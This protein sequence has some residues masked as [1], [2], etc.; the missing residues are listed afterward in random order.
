MLT[1]AIAAE[2]NVPF[3]SLS[4]ADLENKYFGESSK[5]LAAT[6]SYARKIQP[7]VIFFDEIDGL[8]RQRS[9]ADQSCVYGFKT[10][11]LSQMD[12]ML[13]LSSDRF[14]VIGCTNC[15]AQLDSAVK[16]RLP[17]QLYVGHPTHE[18]LVDIFKKHT[19][20]DVKSEDLSRCVRTMR[21]HVSGSDVAHIVKTAWH[22]RMQD[23]MAEAR[24]K[25]FLADPKSTG[26]EMQV[27]AGKIDE[28]LL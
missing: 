8:I 14:I 18:E 6:F 26:A 1:R 12:G 9:D 21:D 11:F 24:F 2:A 22:I 5:L 3:I 17:C 23:L 13:R 19:Y 20:D 27:L 10:E 16:R 15:L 25:E 4:L 28:K 7:C